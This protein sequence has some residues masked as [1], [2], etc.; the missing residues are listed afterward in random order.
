MVCAIG[1]ERMAALTRLLTSGNVSESAADDF[2]RQ[3]LAVE[4]IHRQLHEANEANLIDEQDMHIFD[5]RPLADPLQLVSC[6][7][8]KK[9]IKASQYALHAELCT[10]LTPVEEIG[11]ELAGNTGRKKPPRKERRKSLMVHSNQGTSSVSERTKPEHLDSSGISTSQSQP[12]TPS[13]EA[14]KTVPGNT[15]SQ[16]TTVQHSRKRSRTVTTEGPSPNLDH[17][18]SASV[19]EYPGSEE[20]A[21]AGQKTD[22]QLNEQDRPKK[23][24]PD[25]PAPLATKIYYSRGNSRLRSALAHLYHNGHT[26]EY[27]SGFVHEKAIQGNIVAA[28]TSSPN[29]LYLDRTCDHQLDKEGKQPTH[30]VHK[31]DQIRTQISELYSC[32]T[33][34]IPHATSISSQLTV[35]NVLRPQTSLGKMSSNYF[36]NSYS[37]ADSSGKSLG[38]LQQPEGSVSVV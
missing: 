32:R 20:V 36:T 21:D 38:S 23:V 3:K 17:S 35:N 18:A 9:P 2:G 28:L 7:A 15:S 1:S 29:S 19:N 4:Y 13:A 34:G 11:L 10:S 8:C 27:S 25:V 6:N 37:F 22:R 31:P 12:E 14:K 24:I 30:A 5:L 16:V 26:E 33:G